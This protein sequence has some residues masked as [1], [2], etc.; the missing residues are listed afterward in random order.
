MKKY[1][2][3]EFTNILNKA[4]KSYENK[5]DDIEIKDE[6]H[7][8]IFLG[9]NIFICCFISETKHLYLMKNNNRYSLVSGLQIR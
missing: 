2:D 8:H 6:T 4:I 1:T 7:Y 9:K 3:E 5:E